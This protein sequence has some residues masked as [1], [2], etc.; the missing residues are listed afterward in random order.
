[1]GTGN[2]IFTCPE[3]VGECYFHISRKCG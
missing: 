2:A 3:N 1:V